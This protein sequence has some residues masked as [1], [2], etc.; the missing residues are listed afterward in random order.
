LGGGD[1]FTSSIKLAFICAFFSGC[2]TFLGASGFLTT[3][4]VSILTIFSFLDGLGAICS[5]FSTLI[6]WVAYGM[7][8]TILAGD[9]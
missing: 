5:I 4:L 8:S 2:S 1:S 3:V 7:V 6:S 9:S